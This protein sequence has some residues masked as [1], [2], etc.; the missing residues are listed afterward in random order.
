V[1]CI[2]LDPI[3]RDLDGIMNRLMAMDEK[4]DHILWL[5]DDD[6]GDDE[7]ADETDA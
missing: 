2:D 1:S 4:L 7:E 5:V 3:Q 6:A